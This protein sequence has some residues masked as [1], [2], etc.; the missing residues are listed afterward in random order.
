MDGYQNETPIAS[1]TGGSLRQVSQGDV[2]RAIYVY[3]KRLPRIIESA[4]HEAQEEARAVADAAQAAAE[5]AAEQAAPEEVRQAQEADQSRAE[6]LR[7]QAAVQEA[8]NELQKLFKAIKSDE[9]AGLYI[10]VSEEQRAA[11]RQRLAEYKAAISRFDEQICECN[12]RIA[13]GQ[14]RVS[15]YAEQVKQAG[16]EAREA[17]RDAVLERHKQAAKAREVEHQQAFDELVTRY[18][19]PDQIE[20]DRRR[21][22]CE[23][24]Q[25]LLGEPLPKLDFGENEISHEFLAAALR[26]RHDLDHEE[27]VE[28][29][30]ADCLRELSDAGHCFSWSSFPELDID[31]GRRD[32]IRNIAKAMKMPVAEF[33]HQ[34]A[35]GCGEPVP[36]CFNLAGNAPPI[37]PLS[38]SQRRAKLLKPAFLIDGLIPDRA[39]T[40]AHGDTNA[41][42]TYFTLELAGAVADGRTAFG[43][44]R[45]DRPGLVVFFAGEDPEDV[46]HNRLPAIEATYGSLEGKLVP[47]DYALPLYDD[48]GFERNLDMLRGIAKEQPISLIVNDTWRRSLGELDANRGEVATP[49]YLK[50]ENIAKEFGCAVLVTAHAPKGNSTELAGSQDLENLTSWSLLI[51]GRK[52]GKQLLAI[53]C[54][55]GEKARVGEPIVPFTVD[56]QPVEL[57]DGNS[58]LVLVNYREKA[59]RVEEQVEKPAQEKVVVKPVE[60]VAPKA[61]GKVAEITALRATGMS[62]SQIASSLKVRK[63]TVLGVIRDQT[64]R[65]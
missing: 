35:K 36:K 12:E 20:P 41:G 18:G 57:D 50:L 62:A 29:V 15:A 1:H 13:A 31:R 14:Q 27:A 8:Y 4:K 61:N 9:D 52:A 30:L 7:S 17:A 2:N 25:K 37:V 42:K 40:V 10:D 56:C 63:A 23:E 45:V 43:H 21:E 46:W 49:A 65:S 44:F 5:Q 54:Q 34:V 24:L 48:A 38:L 64:Q 28:K 19:A 55:Q 59:A 58:N 6:A 16:E 11:G 39:V 47:F 60:Q 3:R 26:Y 51:K 33:V 53:N 32:L 22:F